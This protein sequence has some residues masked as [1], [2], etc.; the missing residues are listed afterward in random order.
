MHVKRASLPLQPLWSGVIEPGQ[1][2]HDDRS[3]RQESLEGLGPVEI[4]QRSLEAEFQ[5]D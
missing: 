3:K 2:L 5:I 1:E 4:R